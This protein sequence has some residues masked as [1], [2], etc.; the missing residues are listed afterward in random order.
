MTLR[1]QGPNVTIETV[2]DLPE[3]GVIISSGGKFFMLAFT[4]PC[5]VKEMVKYRKITYCEIYKIPENGICLITIRDVLNP[6]ENWS[7]KLDLQTFYIKYVHQDGKILEMIKVLNYRGGLINVIRVSEFDLV[8][9]N[10]HPMICFDKIS[11]TMLFLSSCVIKIHH[12]ESLEFDQFRD[13]ISKIL[14]NEQMLLNNEVF[15]N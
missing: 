7:G 14:N 6:P 2:I 9:R 5:D 11:P 3:N 4:I 13:K 15:Y 10:Y 12:I 1:Q 8:S